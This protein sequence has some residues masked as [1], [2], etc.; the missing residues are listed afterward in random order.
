MFL[1]ATDR[2]KCIL[3][4]REFVL[5]NWQ[6]WLHERNYR[7]FFLNVAT[8]LNYVENVGRIQLHK[9]NTSFKFHSERVQFLPILYLLK[10]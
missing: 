2:I 8:S 7:D 10:Q 4:R 1:V 9:L 3:I 5:S 6:F